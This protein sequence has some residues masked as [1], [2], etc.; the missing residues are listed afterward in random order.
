MADRCNCGLM[1]FFVRYP[2]GEPL[3][4]VLQIWHQ[5]FSERHFG[6]DG[7]FFFGIEVLVLV[8]AKSFFQALKPIRFR[9]REECCKLME[10]LLFPLSDLISITEIDISKK[11]IVA[12]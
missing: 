11:V 8:I 5:V 3:S 7:Y 9:C 12:L 1:I 2:G 6:F 4:R 10:V